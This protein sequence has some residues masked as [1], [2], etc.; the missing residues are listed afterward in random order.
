MI[1]RRQDKWLF[2]PTDQV[3]IQ[4]FNAIIK[5]IKNFYSGSI[6]QSVLCRFY[7]ALRKSAFLTLVHRYKKKSK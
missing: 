3:V 1:G 5:G 6:Q 2:L 7:F 4:R